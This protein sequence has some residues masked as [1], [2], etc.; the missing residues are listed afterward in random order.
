[1][2]IVTTR[3]KTL[4]C[5]FLCADFFLSLSKKKKIKK[6]KNEKKTCPRN[7]EL[8]ESLYA[9]SG[10]MWVRLIRKEGPGNSE[11]A[12]IVTETHSFPPNPS[13]M[14]S[15]HCSI[16]RS[17]GKGGK[18]IQIEVFVSVQTKATKPRLE[19][20]YSLVLLV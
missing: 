7:K 14:S 6:R 18:K 10:S 5:F 19:V 16:N 1:M 4:H 9:G 13:Q 2:V 15:V 8:R 12:C 20:T 3:S 11:S 17:T